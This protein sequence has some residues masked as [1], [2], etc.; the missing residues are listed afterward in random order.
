MIGIRDFTYWLPTDL[1]W[2]MDFWDGIMRHPTMIYEMILLA[3]F[4]VIFVSW[5]YSQERK[6]WI[7]NWFY[8]FIITYF[9]YR[10]AVGFIQPYSEFWW[11]L[12][13]YQIIALPMVLYWAWMMRRVEHPTERRK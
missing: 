4:F 3:I 9:L 11:W 6:W 7:R 8:L 5:L 12:S 2:G 10:F 13:T 1:P